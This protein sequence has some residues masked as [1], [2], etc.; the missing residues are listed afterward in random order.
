MLV[1]SWG[2]YTMNYV[3]TKKGIIMAVPAL[4]AQYTTYTTDT[5]T[6]SGDMNPGLV[7][8]YIAIILVYVIAMWRIFTKAKKPGWA[9]LIPIYNAYVQLKIINRPGWWILLYFIPFVNLV[10]SI[11]VAVDLAKAFGKS[12]AF[13]VIGLWLF[14]IVGYLILG[15][16]DA[17]YKMPKRV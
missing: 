8:L 10:V 15:Y 2:L 12:T 3:T 17:Q 11:V 1:F 9:A 4:F 6:S 14:S 7:L 13:G 16:G 5:T